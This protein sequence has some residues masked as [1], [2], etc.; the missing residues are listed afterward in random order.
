MGSREYM[1]EPGDQ[2]VFRP[3]NIATQWTRSRW[4][5]HPVVRHKKAEKKKPALQA[6]LEQADINTT[7][8]KNV[9]WKKRTTWERQRHVF[10]YYQQKISR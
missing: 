6:E 1:N 9:F 8:T 2:A 10:S 4:C 7:T 5:A 3:L